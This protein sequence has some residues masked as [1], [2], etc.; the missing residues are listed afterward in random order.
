M[1]RYLSF[2][3]AFWIA[4]IT[5]AGVFLG[6]LLWMLRGQRSVERGRKAASNRIGVSDQHRLHPPRLRLTHVEVGSGVVQAQAVNVGGPAQQPRLTSE[7]AEEA[8]CRPDCS[9]HA[10]G[11]VTLRFE[12]LSNPG[13]FRF[14]LKYQDQLGGRKSQEFEISPAT[15]QL[16]RL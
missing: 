7:D 10:G 3:I 12:F 4:L 9:W 13:P 2:D 6:G 8:T 15:R 14:T 11:R 5:M 1:W 16:E